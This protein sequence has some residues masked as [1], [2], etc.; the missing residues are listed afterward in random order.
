MKGYSIRKGTPV[1]AA[2]RDEKGNLIVEPVVTKKDV[3]YTLEDLAIDP[4]FAVE[5]MSAKDSQFERHF[6]QRGF[7][8]F[9]LNPNS[10]GYELLICH[11]KNIYTW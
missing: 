8:G 9:K 5:P 7:F 1:L 2:K 10:K 6:G 3:L 4:M 11:G